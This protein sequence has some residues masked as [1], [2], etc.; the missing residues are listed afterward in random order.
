M[1]YLGQGPFCEVVNS[2][3][4]VISANGILFDSS[5]TYQIIVSNLTNPNMNIS[6][7]NFLI[8]S[9]YSSDIYYPKIISS[10]AF[11]GPSLN[12]L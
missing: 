9:Y 3:Q 8:S 6:N 10:N 11:K 5:Q 1:T 2:Y 7:L 12:V 4:I